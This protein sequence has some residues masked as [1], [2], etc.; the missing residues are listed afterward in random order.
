MSIR[1]YIKDQT[2][3]A[4]ELTNVPTD[5]WTLVEKTEEL[6]V[7]MSQLYLD[8]PDQTWET[9]LGKDAGALRTFRVIE[10]EFDGDDKVL[11]YGHTGKRTVTRSAE[12]VGGPV[13]RAWTM[14][15]ADINTVFGWRIVKTAAA[16]RPAETDVE[17]IQWM[18]ATPMGDIVDDATTY[19]GTASPVN[20]DAANYQFQTIAQIAEDCFQASGNNAWLSVIGGTGTPTYQYTFWYGPDT[21]TAYA[22]T[23]SLSNDPSDMDLAA[24]AAGT[25]TVWPVSEDTRVEFIPDR[26]ASGVVIPYEGGTTYRVKAA[27]T[28]EFAKRDV[29]MPSLNVKSQTK[30]A[31]R[32]TRYLND[33][34]EEE[35]RVV[36]TVR[37]PKEK[38][39]YIRA[40]MSISLKLTHIPGWEAA[41][42]CRILERQ[43]TPRSAG[44]FYDLGL[45]IDSHHR[46]LVLDHARQPAPRTDEP[47]LFLQHRR[48]A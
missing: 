37:L 17:R 34:D 43:I 2:G 45:T 8:D 24:I 27:T 14:E 6:A 35:E 16:D 13:S 1:W 26:I 46:N 28:T 23:F 4:Y 15:L 40:G 31:A 42:T 30:A 33:L 18:L 29:V 5:G 39:N 3:T 9:Y 41:R 38:V 19:V 10:D 25:A 20:M 7:G 47:N 36:T 12:G 32:A 11:Y 21:G 48:V 22:S 44:A